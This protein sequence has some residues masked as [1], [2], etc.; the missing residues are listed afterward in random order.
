MDD[1]IGKFYSGCVGFAGGMLGYID[2]MNEPI[3][4][5]LARTIMIAAVSTLTGLLL[6]EL[7]MKI[8]HYI[9]R[10]KNKYK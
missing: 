9:V 4:I 2:N 1:Q 10:I 3:T 6:R 8:R 5:L 7:Y